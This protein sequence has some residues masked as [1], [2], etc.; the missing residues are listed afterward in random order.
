MEEKSASNVHI[1][2]YGGDEPD[3]AQRYQGGAAFL[4]PC[5]TVR[6]TRARRTA[7]SLDGR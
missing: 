6:N 3:T 7:P 5:G 4:L 2:I 1:N